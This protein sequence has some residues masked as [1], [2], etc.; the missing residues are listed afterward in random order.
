MAIVAGVATRNMRW[1][2]AD[3]S[4]AVVAGTASSYY[5]RV[6]NGQHGRKQIGRV[7]ILADI[8]CLNVRWVLADC[9]CTVVATDAIA[10]DIDVIEVCR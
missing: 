10:G 2:L 8:G 3:G 4:D 1:V 5:L 6:I 9:L 7:A